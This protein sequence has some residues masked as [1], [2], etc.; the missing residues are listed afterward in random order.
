MLFKVRYD[1]LYIH[2]SKICV[3]KFAVKDIIRPQEQMFL[4]FILSLQ[5]L[6]SRGE[7]DG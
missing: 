5:I 6:N 4:R 2:F 3:D 1:V 7:V